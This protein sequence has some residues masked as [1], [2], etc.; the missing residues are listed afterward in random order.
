M[1]EGGEKREATILRALALKTQR[2]GILNQN[3]Y[4]HVF[5]VSCV[6]TFILVKV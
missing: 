2:V 6:A 4:R 3:V 5:F 1:Q